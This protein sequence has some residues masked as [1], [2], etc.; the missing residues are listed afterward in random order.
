MHR[1]LGLRKMHITEEVL[2]FG[3]ATSLVGILTCP[4]ETQS[5]VHSPA[6][7]LL[8]VG[9]MHRV[10]PNRLYVKVA[11]RVAGQG[12]P[13][14]R[15]DLSGLGDSPARRDHIPAS[16]S[17]IGETREAMSQVAMSTGV[18]EFVLMGICSGANL[19]YKVACCDDRVVGAALI[20]PRY[21]LHDPGDKSDSYLRHRA[22]VRHYFRIAF[23]SSFSA[24][25]WSNVVTGQL[26]RQSATRAL[27]GFAPS[28][29]L[30]RSRVTA[31]AANQAEAGLS[32]LARRG[33]RILHI[34]S[35]GDEGL[36][37]FR[38][39]LGARTEEFEGRGLLDVEVIPGANHT[40]ALLAS[41][42]HV[43]NIVSRWIRKALW[44]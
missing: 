7:I 24:K 13:V 16:K 14:L 43:V 30:S 32:A 34:Y 31:A 21:H 29:L 25:I 39:V 35:E 42:E 22:F 1:K 6:V 36:D 2:S 28:G 41:Q 12:F 18:Q 9:I 19:S 8:N 26:R 3:Q 4:S 23:F 11:R 17:R 10:G 20:N 37:Y 5:T 40:F 27:K 44:D 33:V 15:F 38:T